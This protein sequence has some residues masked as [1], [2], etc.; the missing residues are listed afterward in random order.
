M[1]SIDRTTEKERFAIITKYGYVS[2]A[3]EDTYTE[4]GLL[5]NVSFTSDIRKAELF[6]LRNAHAPKYAR[7]VQFTSTIEEWAPLING[8]IVEVKVVKEFKQREAVINGQKSQKEVNSIEYIYQVH[9]FE[10][11]FLEYEYKED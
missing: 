2:E 9:E 6:H 7:G 3:F 4:D 10:G 8:E 1:S 5:E 11:A